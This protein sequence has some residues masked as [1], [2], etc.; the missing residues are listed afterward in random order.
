MV[1]ENDYSLNSKV[2]SVIKE[3]ENK[4]IFFREKASA[5][6]K[7]TI[8]DMYRTELKKSE[9]STGAIETVISY[10]NTNYKNKITNSILAK[11]TGYHEY[12][13]N[14]IFKKQVGITIHKFIMQVRINEAK[15][16]LMTT[17]IP[18]YSIAEATGFNSD[19]HLSNCFKTYFG[20]S[21]IEYKNNFKNRI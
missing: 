12:H 1:I 8:V 15:K 6:L 13:L 9:N 7:D 21:P 4:Q 14:R 18:I 16:L 11:L 10:I 2:K 17:D 5:V 19:T 20:Y 3:F